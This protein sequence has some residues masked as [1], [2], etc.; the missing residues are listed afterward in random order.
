MGKKNHKKTIRSLMKRIEEHQYKIRQESLRESP[1]EGM[2]H[3]WQAEI[4]AF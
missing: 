1:D 4:A 2:I 3:H